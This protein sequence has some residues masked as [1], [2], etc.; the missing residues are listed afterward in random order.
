MSDVSHD[1][2]AIGN[3]LVDVIA[4]AGDD[5]LREH[6]IPKGGMM[7][8]DAERAAMLYDVIGPTM[9]I[10]GGS[11]GNTV[12]GI[13]SLG[14]RPAYMGKVQADQLGAI[15]RHDMHA[16]GVHFAT[17]M[18]ERRLQFRNVEVERRKSAPTG[19]C[20]ILVTPDAQRSMCT[21]LGAAVEF[22]SEDVQ[23]D[24]IRN[25]QITYLEGYLFDPPEAKKAFYLA[26]K[27]A[28]ESG[29]QLSLTLSDTFCVDRHR[30]EF[31]DLIKTNVDILFA[32]QNELMALYKTTDLEAA[33]SEARI[34]CKIAVTTRSEKG[35]I[36]TSGQETYEVAAAPVA[37]VVDTTGAGDLYAAGFLYGV[38]Q[39]KSL[40]ESGRIGAI[41]AAEVISHYGPRPQK[42]LK[43]LLSKKPAA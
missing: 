23:L 36:I 30:D 3:A 16:S 18:G 26:A 15:F 29:R 5:F 40:E 37:K 24:V 10:S 43:D 17:S 20:I 25:S 27:T 41:A 39:G 12:A 22:R 28:H 34:H 1:V 21:Y 8:I 4:D 35:A 13:A 9:Q 2:C 7:L 38:T 31:L 19:R 14:G 6:K 32:N 42:K 33:I 11:A